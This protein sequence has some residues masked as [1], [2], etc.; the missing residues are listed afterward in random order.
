MLCGGSL[1]SR[2][3]YFLD[4]WHLEMEPSVFSETSV[5]HYHYTLR[6]FPEEHRFHLLRGGSL[7]TLIIHLF[8]FLLLEDGTDML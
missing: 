1:K 2:L 5:M 6:N 4:S 8:G 3:V 7:K